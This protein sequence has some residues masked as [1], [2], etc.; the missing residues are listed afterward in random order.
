MK[1]REYDCWGDIVRAGTTFQSYKGIV[2]A[3]L[4]DG[5]VNNGRLI[6]LHEYTQDVC[7]MCSVGEQYRIKQYHEE[8]KYRY[9]TTFQNVW[10]LL[11]LKLLRW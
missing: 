9:I 1:L 3:M 6:A 4:S 10:L 8:I 5:I 11:L 7:K 2:N